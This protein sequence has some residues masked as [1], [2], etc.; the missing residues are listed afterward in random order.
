MW[1]QHLFNESLARE[2]ERERREKEKK[3]KKKREEEKKRKEKEACQEERARKLARA[4]DAQGEDEAHDKKGNGHA[5]YVN[6]CV[7]TMRA[8]SDSDAILDAMRTF[9]VPIFSIE[10]DL[11]PAGETGDSLDAA[12]RGESGS[13]VEVSCYLTIDPSTG[14]HGNVANAEGDACDDVNHLDQ[15][16]PFKSENAGK[17]F[18]ELKGQTHFLKKETER[19]KQISVRHRRS[20]SVTSCF[21][22]GSIGADPS[23]I[24]WQTLDMSNLSLNGS[25]VPVPPEVAMACKSS[26]L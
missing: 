18:K 23:A 11:Q 6:L 21:E 14:L 2:E 26:L 22:P 17:Y 3:E 12:V 9:R 24:N 19:L 7:E 5:M 1:R 20:R 4:R 10:G 16:K 13:G 8:C 15:D 25:P